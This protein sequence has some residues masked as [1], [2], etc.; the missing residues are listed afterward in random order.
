MRKFLTC[1]TVAVTVMLAT[2]AFAEQ[3]ATYNAG[4]VS[5]PATGVKTAIITDAAD[6]IWY[7]DQA[8]FGTTLDAAAGFAM[9]TDAP[10][11]TYT[12]ALGY[13]G[14]G[15]EVKPSEKITFD[16]VEKLADLPVAALTGEGA[17]IDNGNGT[18]NA[19]FKADN[20]VLTGYNSLVFTF[21]EGESST[22]LAYPLSELDIPTISGDGAITLAIQLNNIPDKYKENV[23][24]CFSAYEVEGG[25]G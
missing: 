6:S 24:L 19:A 21:V 11:G 25:N 16:I 18:H 12:L 5:Y 7:I 9:K 4:V 15:E 20:V 3:T 8:K 14:V 10:V 17:V 23:S 13:T 22:S 1:L 2:T